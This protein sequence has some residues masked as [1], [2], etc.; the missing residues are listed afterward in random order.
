MIGVMRWPGR[1]GWVAASAIAALLAYAAPAGA[2]TQEVPIAGGT[3]SAPPDTLSWSASAI[4]QG[5]ETAS[6][7]VLVD[8]ASSSGRS[9]AYGAR[10]VGAN[11][12]ARGIDGATEFRPFERPTRA[13]IVVGATGRRVRAVKIYFRDGGKK[14]ART[15][16]GAGD[17]GTSYRYFAVGRVVSASRAGARRVTQKIEALDADGDV[18]STTREIYP[19]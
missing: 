9:Q 17:W 14:R 12:P 1:R 5:L 8:V 10:F 4:P 19:V 7:S 16:A 15:R 13:A 18:L 2:Q 3:L 6:T 11:V